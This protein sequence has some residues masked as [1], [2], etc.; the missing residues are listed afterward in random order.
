MTNV[1]YQLTKLNN[2]ERNVKEGYYKISKR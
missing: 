1:L 2:D